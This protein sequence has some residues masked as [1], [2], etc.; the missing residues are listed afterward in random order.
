TLSHCCCQVLQCWCTW[1]LYVGLRSTHGTTRT[2]QKNCWPA[3]TRVLRIPT[4]GDIQTHSRGLIPAI[5]RKPTSSGL[6]TLKPIPPTASPDMPG[7]K[8][9]SACVARTQKWNLRR[10]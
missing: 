10:L 9:P 8:E 2:S 7:S 1:K 4:P 6:E 5:S 3:C